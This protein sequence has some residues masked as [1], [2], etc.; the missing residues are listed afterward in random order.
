MLVS[1]AGLANRAWSECWFWMVMGRSSGSASHVALDYQRRLGSAGRGKGWLTT[2]DIIIFPLHAAASA[3]V[4]VAS[5]VIIATGWYPI[6]PL[7]SVV[8]G[9]ALL[10]GAWGKPQVEMV[11]SWASF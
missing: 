9:F 8:I 1:L 7:I 3:A 10:W 2:Q 6:D 5:L 4:V 11:G